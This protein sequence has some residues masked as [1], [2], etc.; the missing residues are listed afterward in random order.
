MARALDLAAVKSGGLISEDIIP[1]LFNISPVDL[2]MIDS[3]SSGTAHNIKKEFTD[4]VLA[5]PSSTNRLYENQ[6]LATVDNSAH[7]LRY[8]NYCQQMGKVIRTSQRGRDVQLTYDDDEFLSQLMDAGEELRLDEEAAVVSRNAATAEVDDPDPAN[9]VGPL[10]AGACTWA[11]HGTQRGTGG[12]DAVLSDPAGGIPTTAPTAGLARGMTLT[13]FKQALRIGWDNGARFNQV[14]AIGEMIENF[15][16]FMFDKTARVATMQTEVAQSNRTT[17]VE[18]NGAR[19]TGVT[20]QSAVSLFI[21]SFG[22]ITLVPNR[23]ME[24]YDS[25][26]GTPEDVCE[27]LFVDTRYP[28]LS[29]LHDFDTKSLS[30]DGLYD[31]EVLFVD[32][33]FIPA[34]THAVTVIADLA[35][36]TATVA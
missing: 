10:M 25:T 8:G 33:A 9:R 13:M 3:I 15:S 12:A 30:E 21:G 32:S 7:G 24:V 28:L 31:A 36:G 5:T 19:A 29:R 6:S 35:P 34:A 1:R 11:I 20:A 2:P 22:A 27:L 4:K 23:Q 18:G 14:H 17:S 16:D 26:D